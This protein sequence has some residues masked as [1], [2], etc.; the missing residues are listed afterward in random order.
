M[1][2]TETNRLD[3]GVSHEQ[4][5]AA[6]LRARRWDVRE[7]GQA[8]FDEG[9]RDHLR[10]VQP[11]SLWRW[12]PDLAA[13]KDGQLVL[14]DPKSALKPD[15]PNY[16]VE[17]AAWDAHNLM[18][19]ML[20][21]IVWVFHDFKAEYVHRLVPDEHR[22]AGSSDRGSG[23]AFYLFNKSKVT[24]T[25]DDVFGRPVQYNDPLEAPF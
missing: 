10:A 21:P 18:R 24:T 15:Y 5:T 14:V 16:A 17:A 3:L 7:F 23:T 12:L 22:A 4:A 25:F 8:L 9:L 2:A 13:Y 6:M 1:T 20:L 19:S 11:R